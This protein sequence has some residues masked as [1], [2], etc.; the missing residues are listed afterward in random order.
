MDFVPQSRP[1]LF[2]IAVRNTTK[3]SRSIYSVWP[4]DYWHIKSVKKAYNSLPRSLAD[5]WI[6]WNMP[7]PS[8]RKQNFI[9]LLEEIPRGVKWHTE[10]QTNKLLG[11]MSDTHLDKVRLAVESNRRIVGGVYKRTRPD[12]DGG[13]VQRAEVRFDDVA[14]C[15]RTALCPLISF[16]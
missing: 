15:L 9:D 13:K 3:I 8:R 6:W 5:K 1:R 7:L 11:M 10:E 16:Q 14:G 12:G 4:E 2:I